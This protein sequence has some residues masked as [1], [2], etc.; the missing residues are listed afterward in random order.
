MPPEVSPAGV[1]A[2]GLNLWGTPIDFTVDFLAGPLSPDD[3][4]Q[5]VVARV[6]LAPQTV[7]RLH[8]A[9]GGALDEHIRLQ[10]LP[11]QVHPDS[12]EE[13]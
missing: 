3:S 1:Y 12:T 8:A 11:G 4:S 13:A 7:A 2:N 9:L 6:R 5:L 10:D